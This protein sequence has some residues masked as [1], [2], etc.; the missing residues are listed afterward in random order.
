MNL[1]L[2][3]QGETC[4]QTIRDELLF[5]FKR[6]NTA[7][8]A[9]MLDEAAQGVT[10]TRDLA[11][12]VVAERTAVLAAELTAM[13]VEGTIARDIREGSWLVPKSPAAYRGGDL[14]VDLARQGKPVEATGTGI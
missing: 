6:W 13:R 10:L 8:T 7:A 12:K 2:F 14:Q 4:E 11:E 9:V 3:Q 1:L 5:D